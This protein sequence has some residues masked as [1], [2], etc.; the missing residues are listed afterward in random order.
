[1]QTATLTV[2][3][4]DETTLKLVLAPASAES[5]ASLADLAAAFQ[6]MLKQ[7]SPQFRAQM[8]GEPG[9][10]PEPL[11][12]I[13]FDLAE[14]TAEGL[15]V[16]KGDN[17]VEL[18]V[19]MKRPEA[20]VNVF[21]AFLRARELAKEADQAAFRQYTL[22]QV[23]FAMLNYEKQQKH[24][25]PAA[26]RDRNG[27]PLLSWRVQVLPYLNQ[28]ALYERFHLDEPWDSPHNKELISAMPKV[29]CNAP[30]ES[31]SQGLTAVMVFVGQGAPFD[32]PEGPR[33]ADVTDGARNTIMIVHA[34]KDRAVPWTKPEDLTFAPADP[35]AALG[36]TPAGGFETVFFDGRPM[37][38][39]S[40][41]EPGILRALITHAG[42]ELINSDVW[43]R[44][45]FGGKAAGKR[46]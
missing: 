42:G 5:N 34:G 40:D 9:R 30:R 21:P 17:T 12:R 19:H 33:R 18:S 23:G 2:N 3:L 41:V 24:F 14:Q 44:A 11:K 16:S 20:L 45:L 22:T 38:I 1:L 27:K 35:A 10:P 13:F 7:M 8:T 26:A 29:F 6:E 31:A 39:A 4:A 15:R 37:R 43:E 46:E 28:Q 32:D 25:P 36:T